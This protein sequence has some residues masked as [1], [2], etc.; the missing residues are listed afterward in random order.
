[1]SCRSP[2]AEAVLLQ[3]Y[4]KSSYIWRRGSCERFSEKGSGLHSS[5]I[6]NFLTCSPAL[7]AA[8]SCRFLPAVN[9]MQSTS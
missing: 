7:A 2:L 6:G 5:R 4:G 8:H 3:Q 9:A 1:M